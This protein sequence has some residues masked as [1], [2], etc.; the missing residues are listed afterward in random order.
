[1][2]YFHYN[3]LSSLRWTVECRMVELNDWRTNRPRNWLVGGLMGG[4][5]WIALAPLSREAK[6][7]RLTR[8]SAKE[9]SEDRNVHKIDK[10]YWK[11]HLRREERNWK[12]MGMVC[13]GVTIFHI[14]SL[15][16]QYVLSVKVNGKN[17]IWIDRN[18]S[19]AILFECGT[20]CRAQSPEEMSIFGATLGPSHSANVC[21]EFRLMGKG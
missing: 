8:S 7:S 14:Y 19:S 1:M 6:R 2:E 15:R 9:Q 5:E 21:G 17:W 13:I 18:L 12:W 20:E 11:K 10:K 4:S 3:I 16:I